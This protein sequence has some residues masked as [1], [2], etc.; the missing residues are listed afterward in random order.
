MEPVLI[1]EVTALSVLAKDSAIDVAIISCSATV[2]V[3]QGVLM[4]TSRLTIIR[5]LWLNAGLFILFVFFVY[6]IYPKLKYSE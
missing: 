1:V 6:R 2:P 5:E 3:R 4:A